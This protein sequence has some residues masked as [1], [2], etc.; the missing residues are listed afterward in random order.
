M[1]SP[2]LDINISQQLFKYVPTN[3]SMESIPEADI[4][5]AIGQ[6]V[7]VTINAGTQVGIY[8]GA[9]GTIHSFGFMN[10]SA[11][12]REL[13]DPHGAAPE[14]AISQKNEKPIIFVQMDNMA[15]DPN[16]AAKYKTDCDG[17][18]ED[19]KQH[20]KDLLQYS[21]SDDTPRL[22]PFT[23]LQSESC[24][25]VRG[26][27]YHRHQYPLLPAHATSVH[28]SQGITAS[29]GSVIDISST[30]FK[31]LGMAYVALSRNKVVEDLHLLQKL[32]PSQFLI[33]NKYK[34]AIELEY[35]RLKSIPTL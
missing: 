23:I 19:G 21:C 1:K 2:A 30:D 28:K 18:T 25:K 12:Q 29:N 10:T 31:A 4:V 27:K 15:I 24:V 14:I 26:G 33:N 32:T 22:I 20:D 34:I 13:L 9:L 7:R 17:Y 16:R 8:N 35:A 5:Y 6:R 11:V 3:K